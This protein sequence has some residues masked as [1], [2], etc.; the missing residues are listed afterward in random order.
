MA[1]LFCSQVLPRQTCG[2]FTHT[3]FY[4]EYPGGPQ[5]LD[6]SIQGGE[7][8]LTILLNPVGTFFCYFLDKWQTGRRERKREEGKEISFLWSCLANKNRDHLLRGKKKFKRKGVK[9]VLLISNYT[10]MQ[11]VTGKCINF[12]SILFPNLRPDAYERRVHWL[13]WDWKKPVRVEKTQWFYSDFPF[14]HKLWV[15]RHSW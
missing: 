11:Q 14:F 7:L 4:K 15:F 2:L 5:E 10:C 6:K 3:I 1:L 9:C 13:V 12:S 8:F